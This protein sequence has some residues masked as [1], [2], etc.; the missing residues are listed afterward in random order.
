M[1]S[2]KWILLFFLCFCSNVEAIPRILTKDIEVFVGGAGA[3]G[4]AGLVGWHLLKPSKT[5]NVTVQ[6]H[7]DRVTRSSSSLLPTPTA[8]PTGFEAPSI[9][10]TV[11]SKASADAVPQSMCHSPVPMTR[12]FEV[13]AW[14]NGTII[15]VEEIDGLRVGDLDNRYPNGPASATNETFILP[16]ELKEDNSQASGL[17][18]II[19]IHE[20][21]PPALKVTSS[22]WEL[23]LIFLNAHADRKLRPIIESARRDLFIVRDFL[24]KALALV[25]K[26][27]PTHSAKAVFIPIGVPLVTKFG[28][29]VASRGLVMLS[30]YAPLIILYLQDNLDRYIGWY[31]GREEE[32]ELNTEVATEPLPI[33]EE[34]STPELQMEAPLDST[35]AGDE[36]GSLPGKFVDA[37]ERDSE[38]SLPREFLDSAEHLPS[39]GSAEASPL[40]YDPENYK[41][42]GIFKAPPASKVSQL[43]PSRKT[44][45]RQRSDGNQMHGRLLRDQLFGRRWKDS[46]A[47]ATQGLEDL[48]SKKALKKQAEPSNSKKLGIPTE[49]LNQLQPAHLVAQESKRTVTL[50]SEQVPSQQSSSSIMPC[51]TDVPM[52]EQSHGN[53][54]T[55]RQLGSTVSDKHDDVMPR[56]FPTGIYNGNASTGTESCFKS[57]LHHGPMP[58]PGQEP[59]AIYASEPTSPEGESIML[60]SETVHSPTRSNIS[61]I[62]TEDDKKNEDVKDENGS[63][64]G[65]GPSTRRLKAIPE[66]EQ[67]EER[68]DN[69][70]HNDDGK[71]ND[72]AF[73]KGSTS[74]N[75]LSPTRFGSDGGAGYDF[76]SALA[77]AQERLKELTRP[78]V[79]GTDDV[80]GATGDCNG[81][82][83][84]D[85]GDLFDST[86]PASTPSKQPI[87][88]VFNGTGGRRRGGLR[89]QTQAV[90]TA[91]SRSER[92]RGVAFATESDGSVVN[93]TYYFQIGEAP[94]ALRDSM[95]IDAQGQQATGVRV[96]TEQP[97]SVVPASDGEQQSFNFVAPD[98]APGYEAQAQEQ[99][100]VASRITPAFFAALDSWS[101]MPA[102][103]RTQALVEWALRPEILLPA[104]NTAEP[105]PI[106]A[107]K[108]VA[109][110][111][112]SQS[113]PQQVNT[114][115]IL[116]ASM[117]GLFLGQ[118]P[119]D[120]DYEH[121]GPAHE[122]A[123]AQQVP[124]GPPVSLQSAVQEQAAA[125]ALGC[126]PAH[127]VSMDSQQHGSAASHQPRSLESQAHPAQMLDEYMADVAAVS[128]FDRGSTSDNPKASSTPAYPSIFPQ[129]LGDGLP[130]S[131]SPLPGSG[132]YR[133]AYL[134]AERRQREEFR[135]TPQRNRATR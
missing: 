111:E 102:D 5:A 96:S 89:S 122:V 120:M 29:A 14:S 38:E 77:I 64:Q 69:S 52:F 18:L 88:D 41:A 54:P 55:E 30:L 117:S 133:E 67:P 25:L 74:R 50:E 20:P 49:S 15:C 3:V 71:S 44:S 56:S 97:P 78:S 9:V 45:S 132:F 127:P 42:T 109:Q 130:H 86:T 115:E 58:Q 24:N 98:P 65:P 4:F 19:N 134:E 106:E 66:E 110:A 75:P 63:S 47:T 103:Y 12:F 129:S 80:S 104:A 57:G 39:L 13:E 93:Q 105:Q 94:V 22:P 40:T 2:L 68:T 11:V 131:H 37:A 79:R 51:S 124:Q 35:P 16:E 101:R 59:L 23:V 6:S 43:S 85:F 83:T 90:D 61:S 26:L 87:V 112:P 72:Q 81:S 34:V 95:V 1:L 76:G 116:S 92:G 125:I 46:T 108:A 21:Q 126:R 114:D 118:G 70:L 60:H 32:P 99:P 113:V 53:E 128:A 17:S 91:S 107:A 48:S 36:E 119:A 27:V 62:P 33:E 31:A 82:G 123:F 135:H 8:A 28:P 73:R 84:A 121:D 7:K 10:K 100:L